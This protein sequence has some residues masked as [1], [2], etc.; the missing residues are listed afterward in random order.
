MKL[1]RIIMKKFASAS[2]IKE[3]IVLRELVCVY[4]C[5]GWDTNLTYQ[6]INNGCKDSL[7]RIECI[8]KE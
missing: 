2:R 3:E 1:L 6:I 4:T 5:A 8:E 7:K